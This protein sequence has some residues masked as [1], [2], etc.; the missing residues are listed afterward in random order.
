V[1]PLALVEFVLE[2][3]WEPLV[4]TLNNVNMDST[5]TKRTALAP[6]L[7]ISGNLVSITMHV[8]VLQ[9]AAQNTSVSEAFQYQLDLSVLPP[10]NVFLDLTAGSLTTMEHVLLFH[11]LSHRV[12]TIPNAKSC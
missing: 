12:L 11:R 8:W 2:K 9:H 5:A 4:L 1:E 3:I 7:P 6:P 10:I